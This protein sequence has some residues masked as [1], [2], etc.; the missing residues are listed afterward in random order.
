MCGIAGFIDFTKV[1][2]NK[3]YLRAITDTLA[4]RGPDGAGY[5]LIDNQYA[6]IGFGHRRLSIIDLSDNAKQPMFNKKH[7]SW[8]TFNGEIYNHERL[9]YELL[10]QEEF[11]STSDTE[12]LLKLLD[13]FGT[14]SLQSVSGMFAFAYYKESENKVLLARD[15]LG[16]KPLYYS[17][18]NDVFQF[19]SELKPFHLAT[20]FQLKI[21]H[22]A[23]HEYLKLGYINA[24]RSIYK[25]VKK[26]SP[27][28]Y[29]EINLANQAIT[30]KKYWHIYNAYQ[31][32]NTKDDQDIFEAFKKVADEAFSNR[33]VADVEVS[34]FLSGGIDSSLVT[35]VVKKYNPTLNTYT[36]GFKDE[37]F[38]ESSYAKKIASS[39]QLINKT[40]I[41]EER[42]FLNYV[43]YLP[44]VYDEPLA[45]NSCI[46]TMILC[47][48]ASQN[49]KVALSSDGGDE[50][51]FGYNKF[52]FIKKIRDNYS[53]S[54]VRKSIMAILWLSLPFVKIFDGLIYNFYS[55]VL[56]LRD[57]FR[58]KTYVG[59][60]KAYETVFTPQEIS[61]L[62]GIKLADIQSEEDSLPNDIT[63]LMPYTYQ[64]YLPS[65][66][67]KVDRASMF[68]SLE[69]RDPMLDKN[70][71]E[72]AAQVPFHLK[73]H[74][75]KSKILLKQYLAE[76]INPDVFERPKKGFNIP[77][78]KW[79]RG[80]LNLEW[81][82]LLQ[83]AK[84]A[85]LGISN[86]KEI[87]KLDKKL[88]KGQAINA[89]KLWNIYVLLKWHKYWHHES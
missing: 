49:V 32:Q 72:F 6:R 12:V 36:I 57:I 25:N 18:E 78:Y 43:N 80:E 41:L 64:Y 77:V 71:V 16:V 69:V 4:K 15:P 45:D 39:L 76:F 2:A 7:Q 70:F 5:Q 47:E 79:M 54:W 82:E 20:Y 53:N 86:P 59:A 11:I 67:T 81:K 65:I 48:F 33:L 35:A 83:S 66:L 73:Y 34:S 17:F 29:I 60:L 38:D 89:D 88:S 74:Q 52:I 44:E 23:V 24:P 87:F 19:G 31:T 84:W 10:P 3:D 22:E 26:L 85:E 50:A 27:G 21:D 55:R 51:F 30:E 56:K 8:I 68:F 14:E 13:E 40:K 62:T 37:K 9:K 58:A 1:T 75:Q 63:S 42:D 46:P 61:K 28:S